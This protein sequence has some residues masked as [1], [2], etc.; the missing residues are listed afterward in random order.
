[1]LVLPLMDRFG[2]DEA[3][4]M[5]LLENGVAVV[6]ASAFGGNGS[7]G[8]ALLISTDT[9]LPP[10]P[11]TTESLGGSEVVGFEGERLFLMPLGDVEGVRREIRAARARDRSK[12]EADEF[13]L[14]DLQ[15]R[16][17]WRR[18]EPVEAP[19]DAVVHAVRL[20]RL[21]PSRNP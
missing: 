14:L 13:L 4:A 9:A 18:G 11:G 10:A 7:R 2:D 15:G 3:L 1:M 6:A 21:R 19:D 8:F 12:D 17:I 20:R 16:E 5:H